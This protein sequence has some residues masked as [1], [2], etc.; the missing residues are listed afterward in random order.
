MGLSLCF[1]SAAPA[2]QWPLQKPELCRLLQQEGVSQQCWGMATRTP[3]LA[4][5]LEVSS[6]TLYATEM[7]EGRWRGRRGE[8]S[9]RVEGKERKIIEEETSRSW[10][11]QRWRKE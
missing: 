7:R 11:K 8:R 5:R 3:G 10:K 2:K 9:R 6:L 4:G 1:A